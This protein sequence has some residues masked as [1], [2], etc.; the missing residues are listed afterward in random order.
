M[1][2]K[3]FA[4]YPL[5]DKKIIDAQF[6]LLF[7]GGAP[8]NILADFIKDNYIGYAV[9]LAVK[10]LNVTAVDS[11]QFDA[12]ADIALKVIESVCK[13]DNSGNIKFKGSSKFSTY[14]Q[15]AVSMAVSSRRRVDYPTDVTRFGAAAVNAYRMHL[16]D[17][18]SVSE[19]TE[20]LIKER[21]I[22][23][24]DIPAILRL[25]NKYVVD[26]LQ[27]QSKRP[28]GVSHA[29]LELLKDGRAGLD[30]SGGYEPS[31]H[32]HGPAESFERSTEKELI[33]WAVNKLGGTAKTVIKGYYL[34]ERWE[35]IAEMEKELG[36]KNGTYEIKKAKDKLHAL[37]KAHNILHE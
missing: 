24:S 19:V 21:S 28:G 15:S 14:L 32:Y 11:A 1:A 25:I 9:F 29:S 35:T 20:Y 36:L 33:Y 18:Y 23:N 5:P 10:K 30:G 13:L 31:S 37:I 8:G 16:L 26:E 2:T 34:E 27:R 12:A 22:D 7:K 4:G 17:G 3:N 6:N